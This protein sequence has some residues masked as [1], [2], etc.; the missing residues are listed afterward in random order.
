[1]SVTKYF[2]NLLALSDR[3][4]SLKLDRNI[5]TTE[6]SLDRLEARFV[7]TEDELRVASQ[8]LSA[9]TTTATN[10]SNLQWLRD[11]GLGIKSMLQV[12]LTI[13]LSTCGLVRAMQSN[14]PNML[15][16]SP[17]LQHEPIVLED[18]LGRVA[19]VH[20]D[21]ICTWE[22]F[23]AVLELRF[24]DVSGF[25]KVKRKEYALH[26]RFGRRDLTRCKAFAVTFLPG[27]RVDMS[28]VFEEIV[29]TKTG[30][31]VISNVC[32]RC[33]WEAD[34][35]ISS[36]DT[37]CTQ[38]GMIYRRIAASSPEQ[39]RYI[40]QPEL[41]NRKPH[42]A[43]KRKLDTDGDALI[44]FKRIRLHSQEVPTIG[45]WIA[46]NHPTGKREKR[47]NG[48]T[49]ARICGQRSADNERLSTARLPALWS[50]AQ[51]MKMAQFN[52]VLVEAQSRRRLVDSGE[53]CSLSSCSSSISELSELENRTIDEN[54]PTMDSKQFMTQV[55]ASFRSVRPHTRVLSGAEHVGI[56]Q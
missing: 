2:R 53:H 46:H 34:A 13:N 32:P 18:P 14:M 25:E 5:T 9:L 24:K 27:Q 47:G 50:E 39:S 44:H 28:F 26:D 10:L 31:S 56:I 21:F 35:A 43:L 12:V 1:M 52:L 16:R 42:S 8:S 54:E 45:A 29:H 22:M 36:E 17:E 6:V 49:A 37:T 20:L 7:K 19:P 33:Q 38:C 51:A 23:D 48:S 30:S 55:L 41:W 15:E 11:L 40:S 4:T 3:S